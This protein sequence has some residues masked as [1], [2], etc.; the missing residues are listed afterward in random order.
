M[1]NAGRAPL[2][3]KTVTAPTTGLLDTSVLI[4][5]ETGRALDAAALPDLLAVSVITA[6]AASGGCGVGAAVRV[7][8]AGLKVG[9]VP[10]VGAC[11]YLGVALRPVAWPWPTSPQF[12]GVP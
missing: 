4:E 9:Y 12:S 7:G 8:V 5:S 10:I 11:D 6:R 2:K 3:R 1:C